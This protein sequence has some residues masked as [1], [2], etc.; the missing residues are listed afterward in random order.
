MGLLRTLPP[1][2]QLKCVK[3]L[4]IGTC[5]LLHSDNVVFD[6][7]V[8]YRLLILTVYSFRQ[9]LSFLSFIQFVSLRRVSS[10]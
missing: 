7:Q 8:G 10:G 4:V 3:H 6:Q 9:V 5:L 1:H 2:K